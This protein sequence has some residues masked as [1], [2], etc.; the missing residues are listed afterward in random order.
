MLARVEDGLQAS[1]Q[2]APPACPAPSLTARCRHDSPGD[3][4]ARDREDV[5]S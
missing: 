3:V 1:Q 4:E 2:A 5:S